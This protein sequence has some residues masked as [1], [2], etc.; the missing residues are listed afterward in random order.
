MAQI[1]TVT[2][3]RATYDTN[4]PKTD[5]FYDKLGQTT[6]TR[7]YESATAYT[8]TNQ[9]YDALGR[10][11]RASN[12]YHIT[13]DPTYG[14]MTRHYDALGRVYEVETADRALVMTAYSNN[15]MTGTDQ[16]GRQRRSVTDALG[17]LTQVIEDPNGLGYQT[18]YT[19]DTLG[20]LR[21]MEQ[22]SQYRYFMY[23]SL[24]RL[25]RAKNP[26]Q[27]VNTSITPALTE[28]VTGQPT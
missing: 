21:K 24:S 18:N 10:I 1:V 16:K 14:W 12:P 13:S 25:V 22:D 7:V 3:D 11:S 23:D 20:N 8:M 6:E 4:A 27:N 26:K 5:T 9:E 15:A 19:Y 2:S 17:R 28:P